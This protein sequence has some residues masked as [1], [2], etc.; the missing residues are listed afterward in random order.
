MSYY[1]PPRQSPGEGQAY[2]E[3][4]WGITVHKP[5]PRGQFLL[6]A[7]GASG[8]MHDGGMRGGSLELGAVTSGFFSTHNVMGAGMNPDGGCSEEAF[9]GVSSWA[10]GAL[11]GASM[12]S[13]VL[14]SISSTGF[15]I[16]S[17][18]SS[19]FSLG[20]PLRSE[21]RLLGRWSLV[22]TRPIK[23]AR[24]A[25]ISSP[26][27]VQALIPNTLGGLV[28]E[29]PGSSPPLGGSTLPSV[30]SCFL[31]TGCTSGGGGLVCDMPSLLLVCTHRTVMVTK[32][33]YSLACERNID[34]VQM[35]FQLVG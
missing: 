33:C 23:L 35:G 31:C 2:H 10:A 16:S 20:T 18:L 3:G 7:P 8:R 15:W 11:E 21:A 1:T 28:R 9:G 34:M 12:S 30:G 27:S 6:P 25:E 5:G 13:S 24:P 26:I 29:P 32:Q 22:R 4:A 14:C 19:T 17:T